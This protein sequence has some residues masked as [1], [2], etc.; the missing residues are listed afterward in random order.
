[1]KDQPLPTDIRGATLRVTE[2]FH[3]IQGESSSVGRPTVFVRLTGCPLRCRYCDTEYAFNGGE[4]RSLAAILDEIAGYSARY[5][6]VTGGEPLAQ[7]QCRRLLAALCDAGY[8]VSLETSGA[9]AIAGIDARVSIIM[10]IKT[11]SSGESARNRLENIAYLKGS[12]EVKFVIG[13]RA[14][15]DWA[16]GLVSRHQLS[17]R[18]TV[19]FSPA[20]GTLEPRLLA[21]W[22]LA[23]RLPV[24]FQVQLHKYLWGDERGH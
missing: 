5:V 8:D 4:Q 2:I 11:P 12:D 15:Y 20:W 10:D 9:L 18:C 19:L 21:E 3:S 24:C 13:D 22:I 23:D 7:P 17:T 1:M 14:D 6:C 16:Q